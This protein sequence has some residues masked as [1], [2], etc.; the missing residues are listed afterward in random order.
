MST[1]FIGDRRE[2]EAFLARPEGARYA[3]AIAQAIFSDD[4]RLTAYEL[5]WESHAPAVEYELDKLIAKRNR[6]DPV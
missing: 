2:V 6:E 5:C 4:E 3:R 1:A